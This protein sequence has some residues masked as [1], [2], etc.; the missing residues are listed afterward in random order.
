MAWVS[1]KVYAILSKSE[2][3]KDILEGIADKDQDQVN[4]EVDEFFGQG[5]KGFKYASEYGQ[6]KIDDEAE[7]R[8]YKEQGDEELNKGNPYDPEK[9]PDEGLS[10]EEL[11]AIQDRRADKIAK[12]IEE[13]VHKDNLNTIKRYCEKYDED[14][15]Y[16]I[17]ELAKDIAAGALEDSTEYEVVE[18]LLDNLVAGNHKGIS[19]EEKQGVKEFTE[20]LYKGTPAER[21]GLVKETLLDKFDDAHLYND[22]GK[23]QLAL[24]NGKTEEFDTYNDAIDRLSEY[25]KKDYSWAKKEEKSKEEKMIELYRLYDKAHSK[26]EKNEYL[27][28]LNK[29]IEG[30]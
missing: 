25:S 2:E 17:G 21:K 3:G 7:E 4:K 30:K 20:E 8:V 9:L 11:D 23:F 1:P 18:T 15:D 28:Q 24:S 6:A 10:Q 19:E 12:D 13:Y 26:E 5:G 14:Y 27:K 29:L 16:V 22:G